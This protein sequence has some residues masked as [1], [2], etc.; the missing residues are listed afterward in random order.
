MSVSYLSNATHFVFVRVGKWTQCSLYDPE[1]EHCVAV[2]CCA[3][4]AA[5]T[6]E[7][8]EGL[9]RSCCK[10]RLRGKILETVLIENLNLLHLSI[11]LSVFNFDEFGL[12]FIQLILSLTVV[13]LQCSC[14]RQNIMCVMY[15]LVK[16]WVLSFCCSYPLFRVMFTMNILKLMCASLYGM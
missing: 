3:V 15:K 8:E 5:G 16:L 7:E 13:R 9:R 14:C 10:L 2:L 11:I 1:L 6:C 12:Y 4:W